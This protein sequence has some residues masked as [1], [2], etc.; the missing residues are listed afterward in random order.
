MAELRTIVM[1]LRSGGDFTMNDVD[2]LASHI[3]SKWKGYPQPRIICLW[4]KASMIYDLGNMTYVPLTNQCPGTWSRIAL[5]SP[6]MEQFR[7]FLYIDLDT[8]VIR[9]LENIFK[10][11]EGREDRFITLEDFWQKGQLATGLVWVPKN[12]EKVKKIWESF[13]GPVGTRMDNYIRSVVKA[14]F[15]WQQLTDTIHDFKP[16]PHQ[17][18]ETLPPKTDIVCFHGKPRIPEAAKQVLWVNLYVNQKNDSVLLKVHPVT[19][20]IPY[21]VDRGWLG[22]AIASVPT[23]VQLLVS[24]GEGNWPSNF[25]KALPEAKGHYIRWLH[26]D[27]MLTP[28][29]I[30]DS[31]D[32]LLN[33]GADFIHGNAYF[34]IKGKPLKEYIPKVKIPTFEDL[35][36]N[37]VLHS[38]TLMY[39]REVFEKVGLLD[40]RL[41]HMEEY[42]FNLRCLKAGLKIA[43][44]DSFLAYYRVHPLQKV[45][46]PIS[47]RKAEKEMVKSWYK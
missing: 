42:E 22:D 36:V 30:S 43:Y 21:K 32:C 14:D 28:N 47:E 12:S 10:L 34:L 24:Q 40:E 38:E 2:L 31:V 11:V 16:A 17:Y 39:R 45:R 9:S 44:C 5:Y 33:T 8:A 35:L 29:S 37:N 20:I 1:V 27:D 13:K 41:L 15:Y 18:L 23:D 4:D 46:A 6:E 25:N 26:E 7:P 3:R 19:V